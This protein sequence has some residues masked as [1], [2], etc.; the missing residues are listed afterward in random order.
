MFISSFFALGTFGCASGAFSYSS[1]STRKNLEA[2][3]HNPNLYS[4]IEDVKDNRV[5]ENIYDEIQKRASS[6]SVQRKGIV[7]IEIE[8]FEPECFL[9]SVS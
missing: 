2:D 3:S 9:S 4:S 5:M 6:V 8:I 7:E 1:L